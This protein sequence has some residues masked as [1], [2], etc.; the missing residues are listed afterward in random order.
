MWIVI[1]SVKTALP[2]FFQ[3]SHSW[4]FGVTRVRGSMSP[5]S[6]VWQMVGVGEGEVKGPVGDV[7]VATP[8]HCGATP[9][10]ST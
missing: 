8:M 3:Y 4:P 7:D 10:D 6:A 2:S 5:Y 9:L 1:W